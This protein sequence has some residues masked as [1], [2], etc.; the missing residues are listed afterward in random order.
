MT[1]RVSFQRGQNGEASQHS[2]CPLWPLSLSKL[3][4]DTSY[5]MRAAV[6]AISRRKVPVIMLNAQNLIHCFHGISFVIPSVARSSSDVENAFLRWFS[7]VE[8]TLNLRC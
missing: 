8:G 6:V 2:C 5:H 3:G 4:D 7:K 1:L